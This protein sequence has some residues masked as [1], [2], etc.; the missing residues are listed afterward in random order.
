L[1]NIALIDGD[2]IVYRVG[3]T[4]DE[5]WIAR[6]RVR[7]TIE[8][9]LRST[10]ATDY[11]IWLSDSGENWR[12]K[13]FPRYKANRTQP[14]PV[15]Q[16][17]IQNL[18]LDKWGAEVAW[19]QE[20]DD[21]L[22]I[23]AVSLKNEGIICSIDKDLKQIPGRHY[24]FVKEE[25]SNVTEWQGLFTFYK[26]CLTGDSTDNI[27]VVEGLSARGIGPD[28]AYRLLEGCVS[29]NELF[30]SVRDA[31]RDAWGEDDP[32]GRLL[33]TGRLIKIKQRSDEPL[34]NFPER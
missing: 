14:K 5:E 21:A 25:F 4:T 28:K 12:L 15:L 19:G 22:G 9:I 18:L 30:L 13:L 6:A 8:K 20:A 17:Y 16:E 33:L 26:Q 23:R 31:F 1:S 27:R 7:E 10:D 11:E 24:D 2:I 34:W 29:E 3:Y 32:D